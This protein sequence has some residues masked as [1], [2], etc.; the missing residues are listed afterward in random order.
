M[1]YGPKVPEGSLI[2]YSVD[3]EEEAD[4]LVTLA[5]PTNL[6]NEYFAPELAE[7]Q[8]L[9]NLYA[10]GFRLESLHNMILAKKG[11]A[12]GNVL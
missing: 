4:T 6:D 8:T 3:T 2:A 7:E 11:K 12:N 10:F 9:E 1:G 5:C